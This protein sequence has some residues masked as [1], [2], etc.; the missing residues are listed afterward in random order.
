M[1]RKMTKK[2]NR[3]HLSIPITLDEV[4]ESLEDTEASLSSSLLAELSDLDPV[5]SSEF[6][7]VW[8]TLDANRRHKILLRLSELAEENVELNFDTLFKIGLEDK[9]SE[10]RLAAIDGLWE[11]Q[12]AWLQRELVRMAKEDESEVVQVASI[13]ALERFCLVAELNNK[14]ETGKHLA[15]VLLS[16]FESPSSSVEMRRRSLEA[17][18][19]LDLPEIHN[20]LRTSFYSKDRSLK[21]SA[22]YGMGGSCNP[23]WLPLLLPELQNTDPEFRYEAAH[24]CG[25]IGE[26]DAVNG[27]I[28][29]LEDEDRDVQLAAI[30]ALGKIGGKDAIEALNSLLES[31]DELLRDITQQS[32]YELELY[33]DPFSPESL[34]LDT[35]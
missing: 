10:V 18:S 7:K 15:E 34:D 19:P 11:N 6:R 31:P 33:H 8:D 30:Q 23:V 26:E 12:Q 1:M 2:I 24:A 20:A 27:L 32:L 9:D 35:E 3:P 14:Q 22:V 25:E 5:S 16:L 28:S 13:Q 29:L 17:M 21:V 4:L